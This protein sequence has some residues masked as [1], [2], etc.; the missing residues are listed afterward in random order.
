MPYQPST[1]TS[2]PTKFAFTSSLT[3]ASLSRAYST[4]PPPEESESD[5]D[6]EYTLTGFGDISLSEQ[7]Y[8]MPTS[9]PT[10]SPTQARSSGGAYT[11]QMGGSPLKV[12][13]PPV[14]RLRGSVSMYARKMRE[15]QD[16]QSTFLSHILSP[17]PTN[18]TSPVP[19]SDFKSLVDSLRLS[20]EASSPLRPP[21][22]E[23]SL[24]ATSSSLRAPAPSRSGGDPYP[25]PDLANVVFGRGTAPSEHTSPSAKPKPARKV[26][27]RGALPRWEVN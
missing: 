8:Y 10:S 9:S 20:R 1:P 14:P 25:K 12:K 22:R 23:R 13:K 16:E 24:R 4:Q 17:T 5:S 19:K 3:P 27:R 11:R 6:D 7:Q 21:Q 18:S 15:E 2:T 26:P